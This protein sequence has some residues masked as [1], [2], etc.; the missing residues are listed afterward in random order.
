MESM[1]ISIPDGAPPTDDN[2]PRPVI[3]IRAGD[4]ER[5]VDE[6]EAALIKAERGLYQRG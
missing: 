4:I 5:V 3:R 1:T 6:A 2:N